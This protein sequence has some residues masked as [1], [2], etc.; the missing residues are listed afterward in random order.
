VAMTDPSGL[1]FYTDQKMPEPM[2]AK[3][4]SDG[5]WLASQPASTK[6]IKL[7][8]LRGLT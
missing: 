6:P 2:T 1:V 3:I 4:I 5:P 8:A 7:A